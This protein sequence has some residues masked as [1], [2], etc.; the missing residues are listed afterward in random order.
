MINIMGDVED[1]YLGFYNPTDEEIKSHPYFD[2]YY[3]DKL[4]LTK[5]LS[6]SDL[7]KLGYTF[8]NKN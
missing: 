8:E 1:S 5:S 4:L 7:I 6:K 3:K 2:E